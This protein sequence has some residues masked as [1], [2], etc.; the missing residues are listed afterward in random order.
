MKLKQIIWDVNGV[1][2][3]IK[4]CFTK[5]TV[6][7]GV[8][9]TIICIA[10][11]LWF[12]N[13][14]GYQGTLNWHKEIRLA[15]RA[16]LL[17]ACLPAIFLLINCLKDTKVTKILSYIMSYLFSVIWIA[18]F[19]AFTIIGSAKVDNS[20]MNLLHL[21]KGCPELKHIALA[22][23]PHWGAST[24]N[25][26]AR[27]QIL[28]NMEDGD[29][30]LCLLT[31]DISDFG[32]ITSYMDEAV[33]DI[34]TYMPTTLLR[35]IPGNHDA[36]INGLPIFKRTFMDKDDK[37]NFRL[38]SG[39]VHILFL[40][41]LWDS[42]ELSK[43]QEKWLIQQLEEIPQ[44]ETVIVI[45][46]C[47]VVSSGYYDPTAGRY[48]GDLQDV[49]KRLCPIFEKYHVDLHMSGHDH[50][51]EYLEKDG[52]NYMVLGAMGGKLDSPITYNSPYSKWIDNT[53][54]GYVDLV[55]T[56]NTIELSCLSKDNE[57]LFA[58]SIKTN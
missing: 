3:K 39:K 37:Y 47:Y 2:M 52:V 44:E 57:V 18:V 53:V 14:I 19:V 26:E 42:S 41:M 55:F 38:D 23:D 22:S 6:I 56:D 35:A 4:A 24:A 31:G 15:T 17:T 13:T 21:E 34:R 50:F 16:L 8:V 40:N 27:I 49:M 51:F 54:F 1:N 28:K 12:T 9:A 45:S 5:K 11:F 36:L 7:L 25:A 10:S 58:K 32:M 20:G 30:D 48:W 46:H 33:K 29:Y 43:P